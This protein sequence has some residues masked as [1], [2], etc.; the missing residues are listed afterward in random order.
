M[1][2]PIASR[3][4]CFSEALSRVVMVPAVGNGGPVD[5]SIAGQEL[6][7]V[8]RQLELGAACGNCG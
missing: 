4:A 3:R 2:N 5:P 8:D 1:V 6:R 7:S